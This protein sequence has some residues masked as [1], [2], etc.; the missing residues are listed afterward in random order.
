MQL[1]MENIG[2]TDKVKHF[3]STRMTRSHNE[4]DILEWP[5]LF[6]AF[7]D[8]NPSLKLTRDALRAQLLQQGVV[9]R[10]TSLNGGGN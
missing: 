8:A 10:D 5:V 2:A 3:V 7:R 9:Y 4:N 1:H 6:Q